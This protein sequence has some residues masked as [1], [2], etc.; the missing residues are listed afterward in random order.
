MNGLYYFDAATEL[1]SHFGSYTFV[2]RHRHRQGWVFRF[3]SGDA[4][5]ADDVLRGLNY[6]KAL[7]A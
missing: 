1:E 4:K 2:I 5:H 7:V 3:A 6:P